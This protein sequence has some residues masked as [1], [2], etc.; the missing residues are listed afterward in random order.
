MTSLIRA[1]Y[2]ETVTISCYATGAQPIKYRWSRPE[3]SI[4]SSNVEIYNNV[5]VVKVKTAKDYGK[6]MCH[7]TNL[8]NKSASYTLEIKPLPTC[9]HNKSSSS[10]GNAS[11]KKANFCVSV[12][13]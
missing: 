13:S 9:Q 4:D 1:G 10:S 8:R 5:L 3:G 11:R 2:G 7:V 12:F 6:Y